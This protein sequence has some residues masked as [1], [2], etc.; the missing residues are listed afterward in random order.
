MTD[1]TAAVV[2]PTLNAADHLPRLLD[3]LKRQ[4]KAP[5]AVVVLDSESSDGT[6]AIARA[7]EGVEV[8]TVRRSE[9]DHGLTRHRAFSLTS[10]DV[11]CFL[12]QDAVPESTEYLAELLSPFSD[13]RVALSSGRQVPKPDARRYE[14]LV[15]EFSYPAQPRVTTLADVRQLGIRAFLASDACS[16][17]RRQPYLAAGGFGRCET[18]E[19]MLMAARLISA[20]WA[21]AY[22]PSARVLHSHNLTL[23][24]QFRRNVAV[25]RF[26]ELHKADLMG[27]TE[28]PEGGRLL[29]HVL[30]ALIRERRPA[31]AL[32]FTLDCGARLM[33]NRTGRLGT[34]LR[35]T[36]GH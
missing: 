13:P 4:S 30:G 20:G 32:R 14:Q 10:T 11:V 7:M 27:A 23:R 28:G 15:R 36:S 18:N 19:D 9:F 26:L 2:V 16:A 24:E 17:Y 33:G 25:G 6:V 12:T 34:R 29:K 21:V 3:A 8:I 1:L 31:E 35:E 22:A 5:D